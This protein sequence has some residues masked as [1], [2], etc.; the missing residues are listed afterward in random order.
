MI[1]FTTVSVVRFKKQIPRVAG[2]FSLNDWRKPM[3]ETT[4]IQFSTFTALDVAYAEAAIKAAK[5]EHDLVVKRVAFTDY[6]DH[7]IAECLA[8]ADNSEK[9]KYKPEFAVYLTAMRVTSLVQTI[10]KPK[11]KNHQCYTVTLPVFEHGDSSVGETDAFYSCV[12]EDLFTTD[13]S[14]LSRIAQDESSYF[15]YEAALK[16]ALHWFID[17]NISGMMEYVGETHCI[18]QLNNL[19][20]V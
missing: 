17:R 20:E 13:N 10:I 7:V 19:E 12:E 9:D 6:N 14:T 1:A 4:F 2:H 15:H 16:Q 18:E 5:L 3:K 8:I 11:Q